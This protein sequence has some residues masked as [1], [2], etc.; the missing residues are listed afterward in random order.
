M[1]TIDQARSWYPAEDPVHG[2]DHVL[3]VYYLT[4]RL[5]SAEGADM[6]ILRAAVLL[7]DA[8]P[9]DD[10]WNQYNPELDQ[11]GVVLERPPVEVK[12]RQSHHHVSSEFAARVLFGEGWSKERIESVQHCILAHRFRDDSVQPRT[13][14]AKVLFDADKLDAIGAIGVARAIAYAARAG[15]PLYV[16]PSDLF[17]STGEKQ[18]GEPHSAYHEHIYKLSKL[19]DRLY[20]RTGRELARERHRV[21]VRFFDRLGE[22]VQGLS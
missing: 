16:Q 13:V 19:K 18:A 15:Q 14:E 10:D 2:F 7:H 8:E 3:R 6:D 11:D 20:T 9:T 21:M 17:K 5:G 1:P 4:E 12:K 22:E